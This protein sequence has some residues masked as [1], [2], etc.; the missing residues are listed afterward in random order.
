MPVS[1]GKTTSNTA[2]GIGAAKSSGTSGKSSPSS[3]NKTSISK[4]SVK[5]T[6]KPAGNSAFKMGPAQ[7]KFAG[8][9]TVISKTPANKTT[10]AKKAAPG[11]VRAGLMTQKAYD[12]VK[13]TKVKSLSPPVVP[14]YGK[15]G[16]TAL[17]KIGKVIRRALSPTTGKALSRKQAVNAATA[18]KG[19]KRPAGQ[20]VGVSAKMQD[21]LRSQ[22]YKQA[23]R[24][25][26]LGRPLGDRAYDAVKR[27]APT[28]AKLS[29]GA[30]VARMVGGKYVKTDRDGPGGGGGGTGW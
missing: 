7:P 6:A 22:A 27:H 26:V 15:V 24:E 18:M 3:A 19:V 1:T 14:G 4:N 2:G 28:A 9:K 11:P 29:T 23:N 12:K 16:A 20:P 17:G 30:G 25:H 10:V 5:T 21:A 13:N 8:G